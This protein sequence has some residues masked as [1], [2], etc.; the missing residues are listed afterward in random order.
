MYNE[1]IRAFKLHQADV[2]NLDNEVGSI[3]RKKEGG[4]NDVG[5]PSPG[6]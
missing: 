6:I 3:S 4:D 1:L 2:E 5:S